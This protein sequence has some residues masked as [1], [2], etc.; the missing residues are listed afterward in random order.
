MNTSPGRLFCFGLG[1]TAEALARS[2]MADG[3]TVAGTCREAAR[4]H[5]LAGLGIAACEN[6]GEL[7]GDCQVMVGRFARLH[8]VFDWRNQG[9]VPTFTQ[10]G[11]LYRIGQ[12]RRTFFVQRQRFRLGSIK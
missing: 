12:G 11:E 2:L 9:G 5:E 4:R 1:Y 8:K 3:W 7:L 6:V 10:Y